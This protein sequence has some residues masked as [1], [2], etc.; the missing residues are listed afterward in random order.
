MIGKCGDSIVD[1]LWVVCFV[2]E[3]GGVCFYDFKKFDDDYVCIL[4]GSRIFV[5]KD[6]VCCLLGLIIDL[7]VNKLCY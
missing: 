3:E 4:Y 7:K 2:V 5:Y 1:I 6:C